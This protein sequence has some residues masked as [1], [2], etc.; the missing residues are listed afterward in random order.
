MSISN[1]MSEII[2][3]L[4]QARVTRSARRTLSMVEWSRQC[5][6]GTSLSPVSGR[7]RLSIIA[8]YSLFLTSAASPVSGYLMVVTIESTGAWYD[9]STMLGVSL[10]ACVPNLVGI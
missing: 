3:D 4:L 1:G 5:R 6:V 2:V 7:S 9:M 10:G 8:A